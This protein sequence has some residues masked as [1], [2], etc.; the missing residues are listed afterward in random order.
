M[1]QLFLQ[2]KWMIPAAADFTGMSETDILKAW[3][4]AVKNRKPCVINVPGELPSMKKCP[5]CEMNVRADAKE[6]KT[7]NC[8]YYWVEEK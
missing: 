5:V 6:C 7:P 3:D 2:T 4:R 8:A 1:Y